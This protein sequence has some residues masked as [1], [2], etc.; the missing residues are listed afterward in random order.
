[1]RAAVCPTTDQLRQLLA[2]TSGDQAE[3]V[4]HLDHCTACQQTL[5]QLTGAAPEL[6]GAAT[7]LRHPSAAD[8]TPLRRLLNS[9]DSNATLLTPTSPRDRA[10]WVQSLLR[11][12]RTKEALGQLDDYEVMEVLG[13]GGM[14]VVLK[15]YDP[16]L[17]RWVALK[18]LAPDLAGD[19][20]ARQRFAREAQA[21]AKV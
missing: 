5:E 1:M 8:E 15:A 6:L 10:S 20:L 7:A 2:G 13:Q 12:A 9:L 4:A 21:A 16:A 3:L 19:P 18:V 17:K 11:P 14:G